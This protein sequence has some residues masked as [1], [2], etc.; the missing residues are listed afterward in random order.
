[1]KTATYLEVKGYHLQLIHM[2]IQKTTNLSN[3]KN[4]RDLIWSPFPRNQKE[5]I[6]IELVNLTNL[7]TGKLT[8]RE[9]QKYN[10]SLAYWER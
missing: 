4:N 8:I 1:M 10:N 3:V 7:T 6:S 5:N 9:I 2:K